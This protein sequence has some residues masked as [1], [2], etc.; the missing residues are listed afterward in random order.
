MNKKPIIRALAVAF[1]TVTA[2]LLSI[3]A[4]AVT[5]NTI[6]LA[7]AQKNLRGEGYEW[8]NPDR[9]LT[10][11]DL[12]IVTNDDF[13]LK[14]PENCT[15]ILK[16]KNTVKASRFGIGVHGSVVFEGDGSLTV[17]ADEAAIYNYSYSDNH[18]LRF[19]NGKVTLKGATA[20]MADRAEVSMTG[21]TL[22]LISTSDTAADTRVLSISGGTLTADGALK[23]THLISIDRASVTVNAEGS[24]LVSDNILKTENVKIKVGENGTSLESA[25][26]YDG[27]SSIVMTPEKKAARDSIIFGAGVSIIVDY[28]LLVVAV[29]LVAAVIVLPILNRRRKVRRLY[30]KLDADAKK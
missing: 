28:A 15:V 20:L 19:G 3:C 24:A 5:D 17:E 29:L 23:A 10:L 11:T 26:S 13:G 2:L 16:G 12:D 18:K 25:D 21:G 30:E 7:D 22:T 9:V 8:N 4:S 1:A 6:N 14:I 27:E